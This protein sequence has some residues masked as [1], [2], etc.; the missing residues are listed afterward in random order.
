VPI[1]NQ[2]PP[3]AFLPGW[4]AAENAEKQLYR[5]KDEIRNLRLR[6]VDHKAAANDAILRY[7]LAQHKLRLVDDRLSVLQKAREQIEANP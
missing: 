6:D 2:C 3:P 1:Y 4:T 5:I 7:Q